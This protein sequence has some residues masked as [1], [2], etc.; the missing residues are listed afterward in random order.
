MLL[1]TDVDVAIKGNWW[2]VICHYPFYPHDEKD[3]K[4][5]YV[6]VVHIIENTSPLLWQCGITQGLTF[7]INKHKSFHLYIFGDSL[8]PRERCDNQISFQQNIPSFSS[9]FLTEV[10]KQ[11][12]YSMDTN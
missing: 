8:V 6:L 9:N 10:F 5:G 1:N 11:H 2:Y 3:E 12:Y 7:F 4:S